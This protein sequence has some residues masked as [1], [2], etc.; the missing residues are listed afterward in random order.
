ME[1]EITPKQAKQ[2]LAEIRF[3][4]QCKQIEADEAYKLA[5]P[6]LEIYNKFAKATAKKYGVKPALIKNNIIYW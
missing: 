4:Y 6:Y 3:K 2:E 1:K 5:K